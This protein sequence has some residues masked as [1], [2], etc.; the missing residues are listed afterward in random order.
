[1]RLIDSRKHYFYFLNFYY[2]SLQRRKWDR[3]GRYGNILFN[4]APSQT[5]SNIRNFSLADIL[6]LRLSCLTSHNLDEI[7]KYKISIYP[8]SLPRWELSTYAIDSSELKPKQRTQGHETKNSIQEQIKKNRL[9]TIFP[10]VRSILYLWKRFSS[11][12]YIIKKLKTSY[13]ALQTD[14]KWEYTVFPI[15][16]D[17]PPVWLP[18][19]CS[20]FALPTPANPTAIVIFSCLKYRRY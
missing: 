10:A 7:L 17:S 8:S 3:V 1:M 14:M 2:T 20:I 16:A 5:K 13:T 18:V 9:H 15:I 4:L 19:R 11:C 12:R 6:D